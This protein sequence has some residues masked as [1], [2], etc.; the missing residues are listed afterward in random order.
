MTNV[1]QISN[2][3]IVLEDVQFMFMPNFEGRQE[4][5]NRA[6]DRYFNVQV[7]EEAAKLLTEYGVN[8]KEYQPDPERIPEGADPNTYRVYFFKV[9]VY[10]QFSMPSVAIIYDDGE[11]GADEVID[12]SQRTF[13]TNEDELGMIDTMEIAAMDMVIA[14]RDPSPDGIY[15]RLNLKSAYIHVVAN[16][17]QRRYGF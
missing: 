17:L 12:P 10:T 14:R 7:D 13:L 16:P 4:K 8:I 9:R 11:L 3:Q 1:L 2:N 15:A 6:G 5:Y